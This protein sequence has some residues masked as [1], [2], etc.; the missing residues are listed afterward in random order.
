MVTWT[1]AVAVAL[2]LRDRTWRDALGGVAAAL[3]SSI[4]AL[5]YLAATAG[6]RAAL[7]LPAMSGHLLRNAGVLVVALAPGTL[8]VWLRRDDLDAA[9]RARRSAATVLLVTSS[10][11][12]LCFLAVPLPL[13][14]EYKFLAA[15][16]LPLGLLVAPALRGIY[17]KR[18]AVAAAV[19]A[20][21]LSPV[22]T[23][24]WAVFR[25]RATD[26]ATSEGRDLH[27][28][29]PAENALYRWI[30]ERT[31]RDAVFLDDRLT[32]PPFARRPLFVGL[33][34]RR[35]SV[36]E[37]DGWELPAAMILAVV[38]G[39]DPERI[40]ARRTLA[41]ELLAPSLQPPSESL[42]DALLRERGGRPLYVIA[43]TDP[44]RRRLA[45]AVWLEEVYSSPSAAIF[46]IVEKAR[47]H[48]LSP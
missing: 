9:W 23:S 14:T 31:P 45:I 27:H 21:L 42:R 2:G 11:A 5:P 26:P 30:V 13:R 19:L 44:V 48:S 22:I 28:A 16:M 32:V 33:G 10:A 6:T 17:R 46:R 12:L 34:L 47:D 37:H 36:D 29:D 35:P 7:G 3:L 18:P 8:A 41:E 43:R 38:T 4:V 39:G 25:W 24:A 20:L 40:A 15:A 1:G